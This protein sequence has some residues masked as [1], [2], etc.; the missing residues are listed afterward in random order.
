MLWLLQLIKSIFKF[1]LRIVAK[2]GGSPAKSSTALLTLTIDRN[3]N[4]PIYNP[5]TYNAT[6]FEDQPEGVEILKVTATDADL[7]VSNLYPLFSP[8]FCFVCK[9]KYCPNF[10]KLFT[11]YID[12][13]KDFVENVIHKESLSWIGY[14]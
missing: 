10:N 11:F 14:Q 5:Q 7:R 1:Q 2:D 13:I 12:V 8:A 9:G 4:P 3:F 6:I